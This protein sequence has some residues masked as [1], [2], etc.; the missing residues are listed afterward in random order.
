MNLRS[1]DLNLLPVFEA[2]YA[3]RSLTR[4]AEALHITQPAASNALARLRAAFGDLLVVID[5]RRGNWGVAH[6]R[7]SASTC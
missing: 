6:R 2:V 1:I 4:A 5:G 7:G 3:E